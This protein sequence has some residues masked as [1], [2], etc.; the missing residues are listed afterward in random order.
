LGIKKALFEGK[1][2]KFEITIILSI[3]GFTGIT[4]KF[5]SQGLPMLVLLNNIGFHFKSG[6]FI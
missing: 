1:G 4:W 6:Y 5:F 2:L 3:I